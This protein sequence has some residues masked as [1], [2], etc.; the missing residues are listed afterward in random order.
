MERSGIALDA[1]V[2]GVTQAEL[3]RSYG[4]VGWG[5]NPD[6]NGETTLDALVIDG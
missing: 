3:D 4:S 2:A 1:A 5:G 6:E